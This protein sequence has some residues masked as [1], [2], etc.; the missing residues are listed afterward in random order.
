MVTW[1]TTSRDLELWC[2]LDGEHSL[3]AGRL[4]RLQRKEGRGHVLSAEQNQHPFRV[5]A[6]PC[7][8]LAGGKEMMGRRT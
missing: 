7:V 3:Y 1:S 4:R 2:C 8:L 5:R 6:Q